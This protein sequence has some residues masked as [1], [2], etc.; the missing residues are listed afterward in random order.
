MDKGKVEAKNSCT[1]PEIKPS[2]PA[3]EYLL[4]CKHHLMEGMYDTMC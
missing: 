2:S 1:E 3:W 4:A